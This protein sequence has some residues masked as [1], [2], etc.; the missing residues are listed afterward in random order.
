MF[1]VC[2]GAL[3]TAGRA[4]SNVLPGAS[5]GSFALRAISTSSAALA[6]LTVEVPSMGESISEGTVAQ[7]LVQPGRMMQ[8]TRVGGGT[9]GFFW[10]WVGDFLL[11]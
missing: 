8:R 10:E 11:L 1:V 6:D 3:L 7:I 5:A 4:S 2:P 9:W